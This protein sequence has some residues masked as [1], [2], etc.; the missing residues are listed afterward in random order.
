VPDPSLGVDANP[1]FVQRTLDAVWPTLAA[2]DVKLVEQREIPSP[3]M[4]ASG[5]IV[6]RDPA[7]S[8]AAKP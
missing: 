4:K 8:A 6:R 3:R 5:T 2:C 7:A 1:G